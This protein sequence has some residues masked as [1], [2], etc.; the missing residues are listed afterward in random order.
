MQVQVNEK[1]AKISIDVF[2][3]VDEWAGCMQK[4]SLSL[5]KILVEY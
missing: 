2:F 5:F 4:F 3:V 1:S